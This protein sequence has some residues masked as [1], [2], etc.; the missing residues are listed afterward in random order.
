MEYWLK[1]QNGDSLRLP[2]SPEEYNISKGINIETEKV[3]DLGEVGLFGGIQLQQIELSS[4]F[5]A[6]LLFNA[7]SKLTIVSRNLSIAS[8]LFL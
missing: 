4:F 8:S 1:K 3:N 2:V 5:N 7:S 6:I